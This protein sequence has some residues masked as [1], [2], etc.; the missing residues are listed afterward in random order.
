MNISK[1]AA[2][3]IAINALQYLA[4]DE[5]QLRCFLTLTGCNIADLRSN[6]SSSEF[7]AAL[8]DFFLSNEPTLLAFCAQY[9]IDP[10]HIATSQQILGGGNGAG[11]GEFEP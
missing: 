10:E 8:L 1:G 7:Q 9:S 6:A 5:E 4:G 2:E 3:T 11:P